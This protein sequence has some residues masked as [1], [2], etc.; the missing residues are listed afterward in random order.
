MGVGGEESP[1]PRAELTS[2][3][4]D[5]KAFEKFSKPM[6]VHL[7]LNPSAC[8]FDQFECDLSFSLEAKVLLSRTFTNSLAL[9]IEH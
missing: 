4:M 2:G 1:L 5:D 7:L 9:H 6:V 8:L 3:L